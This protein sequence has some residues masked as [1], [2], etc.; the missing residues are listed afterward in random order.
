MA[1]HEGDDGAA[2]WRSRERRAKTGWRFDGDGANAATRPADLAY[3]LGVEET[4]VI[5][6]H[7]ER[8][9]FEARLG[10]RLAGFIDYQR[11]GS[12]LVLVHTEVL[13]EFAGRGIGN[14]LARFVLDGVLAAGTRVTIKCPFLRAYVERHPEYAALATPMPGDRP[15]GG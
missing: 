4:P 5:T 15:A 3:G 9:R 12:R 10:S 8:E 13:E 2:V 14:A 1:R 6:D 11:R 7:P